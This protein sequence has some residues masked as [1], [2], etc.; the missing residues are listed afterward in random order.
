MSTPTG[1]P[2]GAAPKRAAR[3]RR[4][5]QLELRGREPRA[6]RRRRGAHRA[7]RR[8]RRGRI[9]GRAGAR[10]GDARQ[11]RLRQRTGGRDPR[12]QPGPRPAAL[13]PR[14]RRVPRVTVAAAA[15]RA[16][17]PV[18]AGA[19]RRRAHP[20]RPPRGV[21][22]GA[23]RGRPRT[24]G[25]TATRWSTHL[26]SPRR[27]GPRPRLPCPRPLGS[28]QR[29]PRLHAR[30]GAQQRGPHVRAR[31]VHGAGPGRIRPPR[32][33]RACCATS[34]CGRGA[35]PAICRCGSSHR[36]GISM[37]TPSVTS[38]ARASRRRRSCGRASKG[39]RAARTAARPR[40]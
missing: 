32:A 8:L 14:G 10:G 5:D 36:P 17:G 20:D 1:S 3:P 35:T 2:P 30:V 23:D 39:R 16:P 13:R 34:S 11:A 12:A 15:L 37:S 33:D 31:L 4:G 28:H 19:G 38:C 25:A 26:A 6:R 7:L 22:A 21:R 24:P 18:Q 27:T 40:S 9:P 29:R